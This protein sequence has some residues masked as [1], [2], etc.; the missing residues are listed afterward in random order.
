MKTKW[1]DMWYEDKMSILETM[2]RNLSSDLAAGYDYFGNSATKQRREIEQYKMSIDR[3][4]EDLKLLENDHAER[5]CY[6][7]LKKRGAIS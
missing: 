2:V 5:W 7:D 3:D 4:I 1:F 6:Y